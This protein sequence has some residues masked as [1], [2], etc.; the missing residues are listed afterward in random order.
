MKKLLLIYPNQR[1]QK[2]DVNT[3]WNLNPSV[4]CLLGA[5]V[6]GIV[7]VKI[8]DA[9]FYNLSK[10]DFLKQVKDYNPDFA[11]I[12]VLSSEYGLTLDI[13]A[14]MIKSI[15][16]E[17]IVIAGGIHPTI[18]YRNVV[19]NHDVD[20][21]VRGEG[22]YVLVNLLKSLLGEGPMPDVGLVYVKNGE[23]I[24]QNQSFVEDLKKLPW[25]DY[26]LV[27]LEEYIF[28]GPRLGPLRPPAY[29][30]MRLSV[31]RG[32]PFGCSFCQVEA[33]AGKKV[34]TF[35]AEVVVNHLIEYR[36]RYGIK[37]IQF[38]DDNI[39]ANRSF[40]IQLLKLMIEKKVDLQFIIGAF[41]IFLLT[42][43]I[44]EL[45]VKAG[46]VGINVAI[47]T[48]SKRV[49]KEIVFKPVDLDK[50]PIMIRKVKEKGLFVIANFIIGYPGESWSEIRETIRYAENCGADYAKLFLAVPLKN[51][52]LW[53]MA[54]EKNA[55]GGDPSGV[56]VE[57]R[58]SQVKSSEWTS[59]DISILRAYEWDRINF[60][61]EEKRKRVAE[62]W[63]ISVDELNRIRKETRDAITIN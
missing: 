60:D 20:Y 50:V 9:Q 46:C 27:K 52:K 4:L 11:G 34:R 62:I 28:V 36:D 56:K 30:Y 51:T 44:L 59:K 6:K 16:K 53:N 39:I 23:I 13:T 14:Q 63:G 15:N 55:F 31:T 37:S 32:C 3:I 61:T 29:P 25:P 33:I 41:A 18:E 8:I 54:L 43:D 19:K 21:I 24:I 42:D 38:D 58:F 47:E 26:S 22:E 49:L 5:M 40:F 45:M 57:W 12:S 35:D 7:D 17:I 10:N 1:W 2:N 48:G